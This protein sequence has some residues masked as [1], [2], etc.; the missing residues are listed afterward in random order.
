MQTKTLILFAIFVVFLA[1]CGGEDGWCPRGTY[2]CE[3]GY[4]MYCNMNYDWVTDEYC[5]YGC[6]KS[7]GQCNNSNYNGD[8]NDSYCDWDYY[9]DC[10]YQVCSNSREA[11]LERDGQKYYCS[12]RSDCSDAVSDL[13]YDCDYY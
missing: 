9:E 6:D 13:L 4:S 3:D 5:Y 8:G 7:T 12:D 10:V 1:S 2:R 11:W